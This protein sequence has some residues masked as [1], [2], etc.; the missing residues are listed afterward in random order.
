[1]TLSRRLL[2]PEGQIAFEFTPTDNPA[3]FRIEVAL[4]E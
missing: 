3:F 1:V 2:M 4:S